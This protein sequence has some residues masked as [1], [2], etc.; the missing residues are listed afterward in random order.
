MPAG[1][2]FVEGYRMGVCAGYVVARM[3]RENVAEEIDGK[4]Q[5]G[6]YRDGTQRR[7]SSQ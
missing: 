1:S 3:R 5:A 7:R 4:P 6:T 2:M